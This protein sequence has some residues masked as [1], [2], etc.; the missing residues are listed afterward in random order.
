MTTPAAVVV[1]QPLV[2]AQK[3]P[4]SISSHPLADPNPVADSQR[5]EMDGKNG[6]FRVIKVGHPEKSTQNRRW[7]REERDRYSIQGGNQQNKMGSCMLLCN[8]NNN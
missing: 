2:F 3:K 5:R 4:S 1:L 6:H 8:N 7:S